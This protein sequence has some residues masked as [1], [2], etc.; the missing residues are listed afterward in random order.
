[1]DT[2]IREIPINTNPQMDQPEQPLLDEVPEEHIL[3][4][5]VS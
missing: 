5:E 2:E 3:D 4:A 1:M